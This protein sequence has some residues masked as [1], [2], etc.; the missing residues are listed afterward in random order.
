MVT[1]ESFTFGDLISID[2]LIRI[3]R[4][5]QHQAI[6]FFDCIEGADVVA[7]NQRT[8]SGF[9]EDDLL[10]FAGVASQACD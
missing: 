5:R 9:E 2:D 7:A 6:T 10:R 4:V 1:D 8:S 3:A